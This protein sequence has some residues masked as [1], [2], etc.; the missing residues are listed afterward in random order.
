MTASKFRQWFDSEKAK[1]LATT[2]GKAFAAN[3]FEFH[4]NGGG[5][6]AWMR[7][8]DD[9]GFYILITNSE[10]CSHDLCGSH[11]SDETKPDCYLVGVHNENG[12]DLPCEEAKDVAAAIAVANRMHSEFT[13]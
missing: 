13:K 1:A 8:I 6:T 3:N 12:D 9:T 10:G 2:D 5:L 4:H 11:I 7:Q